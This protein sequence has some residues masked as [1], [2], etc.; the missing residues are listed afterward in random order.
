[1][2]DIL[3]VGKLP[4]DNLEGI[5]KKVPLFDPRVI[6]GPG[7]GL[8]CAVIDLKDRLLVFKSDPITFASQEIGWYSVQV[9]ANDVATTGA[10]PRWMLVTALFPEGKTTAQFIEGIN[11][12]IIQACQELKISLIGGHTEITSGLDRA[13]IVGTLIGEVDRGQLVTPQGPQAGDHILLTKG[14]PI[15][16]TAILAREF[17]ERAAEVLDSKEIKMASDFL[18]DPGISVV[19]DA[20]IALR[21]GRVTGMHD[22]TEG[23]LYG[24]LWE[25]AHACGKRLIIDK[26]V[27][28]IPTL[29]E[30][31]CKL[32]GIDPLAAIASGALLLTCHQED[33]GKIIDA[34]ESESVA[35]R[36][37]GVVVNGSAE[38]W[39]ETPDSRSLIPQPERDEIAK[40]FERS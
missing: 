1:M 32:F 36:R 40:I 35:C 10:T 11:Q 14:V 15:E 20:E 5:L 27:V 34:L 23:G 9:N 26:S 2:M 13:L 7:I 38:V 37:I 39:Q 12:Q 4:I 28:H 22:P 24:A 25:L 29:S 21:A 19:R 18:Y 6:L 33:S 30:K 16:A 8:D 3:P 31:I 17:P